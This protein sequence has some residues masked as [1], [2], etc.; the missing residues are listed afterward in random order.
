LFLAAMMRIAQ[1]LKLR[2]HYIAW[3]ITYNWGVLFTTVAFALPLIPYSLGVYSAQM[4][5]VLA[6]PALVLLAWYRWQIAREVLGAD[7]GAA[8][9]ILVF[10]FVLSLSV[11]QVVGMILLPGA[12]GFSG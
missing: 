3:L 8:A 6:L 2:P 7:K 10:D 11:D 4:A 5:V 1:A 12:G 9:A